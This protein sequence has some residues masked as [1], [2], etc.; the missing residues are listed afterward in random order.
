MDDPILLSRVQFA[1]TAAFHYLFPQ[2]TMG[3]ALLLVVLKTL[4]LRRKDAL[5]NDAARFW[6]RIFAITFV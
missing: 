3:M 5:Y 1:F 6:A 4:Y 2:L